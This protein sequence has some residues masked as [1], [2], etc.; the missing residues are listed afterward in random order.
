MAHGAADR[1]C[2][3]LGTDAPH[4]MLHKLLPI[5]GAKPGDVFAH[6]SDRG[7]YLNTE[8]WAEVYIFKGI[9]DPETSDPSLVGETEYEIEKGWLIFHDHPKSTHNGRIHYQAG[10]W[11][12]SVPF[13]R[14]FALPLQDCW[15]MRT[16]EE[17]GME[18]EEVAA[19]MA[20]KDSANH[21]EGVDEEL[22]CEEGSA[23]HDEDVDEELKQI[24]MDQW[25]KDMGFKRKKPKTSPTP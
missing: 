14:G 25:C 23:N 15:G 7:N 5:L 3:T 10:A 18:P 8:R 22:K 17:F 4:R 2:V 13:A 1:D 19:Y 20:E 16:L 11:R 12:R 24:A 9:W 6:A 21:N